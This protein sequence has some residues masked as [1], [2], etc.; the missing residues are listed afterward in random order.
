MMLANYA[1]NVQSASRSNE[2][3]YGS[4][5]ALR[6]TRVASKFVTGFK[7][8]TCA[9]HFPNRFP[10]GPVLSI[11]IPTIG[12]IP[13]G[14]ASGGLCGG[15]AFAVRDLFTA[16][17]PPPADTEPPPSGSPLFRWLVGRLF[18]SFN[19]PTGPVRYFHCMNLPDGDTATTRGLAWR[20]LVEEWPRIKQDLDAGVLAPLGLIRIRSPN[21]LEMGRNH[22]VLAYGY[23][24]DDP[25]RRLRIHV[26]DPTYP[27]NDDLSLAVDV[28]DPTGPSPLV[29]PHGESFRGFFR[30][31][32]RPAGV[33]E[34]FGREVTVTGTPPAP[35]T[36]C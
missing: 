15:M 7:P 22:Q 33:P 32:F 31:R 23:E 19:L 27:D 36:P 29:Y 2:N 9:F 18:S 11:P 20:T 28:A 25:G 16:H 1:G 35:K 14:N 30:T 26:Y 12:S 24:L 34:W 21:P 13:I 3:G 10:P 6:E 17:L 4:L 5:S 8:S